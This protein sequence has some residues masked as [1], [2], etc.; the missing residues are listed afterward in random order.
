MSTLSPFQECITELERIARLMWANGVEGKT[1]QQHEYLW[2]MTT[3]ILK[4]EQSIHE[5]EASR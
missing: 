5:K 4:Y 3:A 2:P 1:L